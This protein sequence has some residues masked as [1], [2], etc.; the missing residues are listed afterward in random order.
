MYMMFLC[1]AGP[2]TVHAIV[3]KFFFSDFLN[4]FIKVW[5]SVYGGVI[6]A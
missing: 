2:Y 6:A 4:N 5:L 1:W 3:M